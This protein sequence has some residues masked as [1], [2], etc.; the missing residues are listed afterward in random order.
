VIGRLPLKVE[1][2]GDFRAKGLPRA[3]GSVGFSDHSDFDSD[4]TF[5]GSIAAGYGV[6]LTDKLTLGFDFMWSANNSHDDV[7]LR[8]GSNQALLASGAVPLD[9][10]SA[11]DLGTG[12]SYKLNERWTLRA[13]Y[14]YSENSQKDFNYTPAVP[15]GDRHYVSAGFGWRGERDGVDVAYCYAFL[16][17][18]EVTGASQPAF[19]GE[20]KYGWHVLTISYSR[21]F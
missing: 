2:D 5:P 17:E 15:S 20:Y 3:L 6:D 10:E 19:N 8:I 12:I 21:R 7:P 18:R 13:G 1:Y 16:N 4:I 9:W 11:I 14:L